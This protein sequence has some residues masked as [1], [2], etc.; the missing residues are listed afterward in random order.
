MTARR[1]FISI[2][3]LGFAAGSFANDDEELVNNIFM[4]IYNQQFP[5]A[6]MILQSQNGRIEKSS[7]YF[8]TLD[9]NWWKLILSPSEMSSR[10]YN[11]L[12]KTIKSEKNIVAEDNISR[13]IW[14]S[15][16]MRFEL[17]RY[18]FIASAVLHSE[19]K[20][21]LGKMS[22]N[23]PGNRDSKIQL[24]YLYTAL[25]KYYDNMLNPFF[26]ESR[27]RARAEALNEI[28]LFTFENNQI[29]S[30]LA[31]YFLGKIYMDYEKKPAEGNRYFKVLT[32]KYPRNK[33]FREM[34]TTSEM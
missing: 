6:E 15:Y 31:N 21:V 7:F 20:K 14:L 29:V 16:Q 22:E 1:F 4:L 2:L 24:F 30:T 12:L 25:F 9:L 28:E 18:N 3:F 27:R 10:Q 5:E 34:L 32:E 33:L 13:L 19:I 26:Q 17:K 11:T 8:L 23:D